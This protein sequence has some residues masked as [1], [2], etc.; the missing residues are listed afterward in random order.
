[1]NGTGTCSGETAVVR[2]RDSPEHLTARSQDA[3]LTMTQ[4][5]RKVLADFDQLAES[6]QATVLAE[7][8]RRAALGPH[9]LPK[10][11]DLSAAADRLFVELDRREQRGETETR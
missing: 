8:L 6:E 11:A 2:L 10:D 7:L 4:T 3:T 9:D 1:M 5:A